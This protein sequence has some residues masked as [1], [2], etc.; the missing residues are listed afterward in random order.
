MFSP[1]LVEKNLPNLSQ[2][3]LICQSV[4]GLLTSLGAAGKTSEHSSKQQ[5]TDEDKTVL[6]LYDKFVF[7]CV[8]PS[9]EREGFLRVCMCVC[10]RGRQRLGDIRQ[11]IETKSR[12]QL[13]LKPYAATKSNICL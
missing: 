7:E 9:E 1:S 10:Q 4:C 2:Y 8:F 3:S 12:L 6:F 13:V 11:A 5:S